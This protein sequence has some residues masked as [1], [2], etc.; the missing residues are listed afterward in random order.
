MHDRLWADPLYSGTPV[1]ACLGQGRSITWRA[2]FGTLSLAALLAA[3]LVIGITQFWL[4]AEGDPN[5]AVQQ[6][7]ALPSPY[8]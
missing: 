7:I 4:F 1:C 2:S 6:V 8:R 3:L 5:E